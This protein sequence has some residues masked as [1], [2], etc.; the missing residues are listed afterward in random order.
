MGLDRSMKTAGPEKSS[1]GQQQSRGWF[2]CLEAISS[3]VRDG[4]AVI[5]GGEGPSPLADVAIPPR[6]IPGTVL[7]HLH[8]ITLKAEFMMA[9]AWG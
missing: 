5:P 2:A 1:F 3:A 7:S 4:P 8:L 6:Q 9:A